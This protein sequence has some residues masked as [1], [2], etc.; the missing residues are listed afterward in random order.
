MSKRIKFKSR[1]DIWRKEYLNLKC[2]TLR[3]FSF[4]ERED[5]R[6]EILDDFILG[7]WNLIDIEIRNL[8]TNEIFIRR[9]TD[10]TFF[11]NQYIISW[12]PFLTTYNKD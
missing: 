7:R 12:S 5:I 10:V 6:K 1:D 9:V 4:E 11:N 8:S 2:N 3:Q